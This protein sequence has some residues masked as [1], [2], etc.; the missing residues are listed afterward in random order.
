VKGVL[1]LGVA[2]LA[3]CWAAA[4]RQAAPAA[5][6]GG[7][8]VTNTASATYVGANGV[9]VTIVSNTV[10][11]TVEA[12]SSVVTGPNEQGCT[13]KSDAAVAGQP[14][15]RTFTITNS[16]NITDTYAVTASA[17]SGA[18]LSLAYVASGASTP[19]PNGGTLPAPL[20]PGA[21]AQ[22]VV[23]AATGSAPL[24]TDIE[25]T[26]TAKS[27]SQ[28]AVNGQSSD[29]A[30]QCA[31]VAS[32]AAIAGA[33]GAGTQV[34]KLVDLAQFSQSQPGATV[35]YT[36]S[37]SNAGGVPAT[38]VVVTD[39]V[40]QGLTPIAASVSI[41]GNA[42]AANAVSVAGQT[43][44]VRM[45]S[46]APGVPHTLSFGAT[47]GANVPPGTT[48]VNTA[49]IVADNA[50]PQATTAASLLVGVGNVV[51]DGV[52]G[53][54]QTIAGAAVGIVDAA[55]GTPVA[56]SGPGFAPNATNANPYVTSTGGGYGFGVAVQHMKPSGLYLTI[57][58]PGYL[59][60]KI[61]LV[62]T[63]AP[64]GFDTA[65][66]TALDGQ[67]LAQPGGFGLVSGPVSL[68]NVTGLFG[69]IPLFRS[70]ALTIAKTVDRPFAATGDRLVY[71]LQF[72]NVGAALGATTVSDTLP[73]G[74]FYAP[75]TGRLDGVA[76]EPVASGRV[77]TWTLPSLAAAHTLAYAAVILPGT[78][79]DTILTNVATVSAAAPNDPS[80]RLSATSS[81]ATRVIAGVFSNTS[82]ITGR[83]FFDVRGTARFVRGDAGIPRVRLYLENG[84][85]VVTDAYGR[86]SFPAV[87]AGMH[88]LV[89]DVS[90]LP[91]EA[92]PYGVASYDD[93]R[94][95][96]R[97]VHGV[98]DA[99]SLHDIDFALEGSPKR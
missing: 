18:V 32:S 38:N 54:G 79:D 64:G 1:R 39:V 22:V 86:F 35:T 52:G 56:L 17:S 99:G 3:V 8:L 25:I 90:T 97:L 42:Q 24:G 15:V 7:T 83:V 77:L 34:T 29:S 23:T 68:S 11:A 36:V 2:V 48:L 20:A 62:L 4:A 75:G 10:T 41:D 87:R 81:A 53:S 85:S 58:A 47:L 88:V 66:L 49:T 96:R 33:G 72:Q 44:S 21:V 73:P 95:M 51:F 89:L 70:Q 14:F 65:Q 28:T 43:L 91:P 6:A 27:T 61:L 94:S 69:N 50:P 30:E 55:S 78:A 76:S 19:F 67:M 5:T 82:V 93:E 46:L 9:A 92:R 13:P 98:F 80:L 74:V 37:F 71:S 31:V 45:A 59:N 16:S 26:L 63:P 12:V 40:P 60:R 84:E 57:V